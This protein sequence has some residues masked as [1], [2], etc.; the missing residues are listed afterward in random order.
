MNA[1]QTTG[2]VLAVVFGLAVLN[3]AMLE[4]K[5]CPRQKLCPV[6]GGEIDKNVYTDYEGERV[7]FCCSACI[8]KFKADPTTYIQKLDDQGVVLENVAEE[9]SACRCSGPCQCSGHG[10]RGCGG[11][12]Q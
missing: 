3:P 11:H 5:D 10:K 1:L 2:L 9:K 8:D 6:M 7:Y 12:D 4:A